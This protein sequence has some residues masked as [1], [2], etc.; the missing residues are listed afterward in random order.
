MPFS[1]KH[2]FAAALAV[3]LAA[4]CGHVPFVQSPAATA[5]WSR[6]ETVTVVGTEYRFEP[7]TLRLRR[8]VPYRLHFA[9]AG[10][11]LHEFTAPAFFQS[12]V[13]RNP[14]ALSAGGREIVTQPQQQK[15]VFLLPRRAGRFELS[16]A[17]HDWE[18]MVGEIIVE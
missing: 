2:A 1:P 15:D 6:A 9:N 5:D 4:G 8:D 11:E 14:D 3:L 13:L 17:D 18:G 10:K 12:V 16:C 7:S